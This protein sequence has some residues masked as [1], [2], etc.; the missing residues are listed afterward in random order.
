MRTLITFICLTLPLLSSAAGTNANSNFSSPL[1]Y[2]LLITIVVLLIMIIGMGNALKNT[3]TSDFLREK[4]IKENEDK[5][6]T[7]AKASLGLIALSLISASAYSQNTAVVQAVNDNSIGGVDQFT[8]Y[9]MLV[10][11]M[12]EL[13]ILFILFNIFKNIL[14]IEKPKTVPAAIKPVT[15]TIFDK[16]NGMVEIEKEESIL[17]DHDYDGIKELDND[18]PPWWKYGFYLTILVAVI[19]LFNFHILKSSPLQAEEY[20]NS[21]KKAEKEIA[22]FMKNSANNVDEST[23]KLLTDASDIQSGKVIFLATCSACHGKLGEGTV[24]PNLTDEYWIHG[25]GV[26]DIFKTIKYGWPDKGM[27]SWKEDYSPI[28]IAQVTS[29]VKTLMGTNP[30]GGKEKQGELY[31]EQIAPV[32]SS[33]AKAGSIQPSTKTDSLSNSTAVL[34][35]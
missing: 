5:S 23:V 28:Q 15:R 33:A 9:A 14:N 16:L 17:L 31:I 34:K 19:Y 22:E 30:P 3:V 25:G 2:A 32:D 21:V 6:N 1:F 11:I 18:L 12:M 20:T 27:K 10:V 4:L 8:F 26:S 29:Y 13:I 7:A 35:K 24:G